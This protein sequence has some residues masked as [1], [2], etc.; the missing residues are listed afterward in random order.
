MT[1]P[2]YIIP[3]RICALPGCSVD[4]TDYHQNALYCTTA[5][6]K[7]NANN[8]HRPPVRTKPRPKG[9]KWLNSHGYVMIKIDDQNN[10]MMEHRYVMSQHLGRSLLSTESV[11][12]I[13]GDKTD[14]H[15]DNLELWSK[16]QPAGQR[17]SDKIEW[18]IAFL[19]AYGYQ[20][21]PDPSDTA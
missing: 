10:V 1:D 17:V 20:V 18:A 4:I 16:S 11:H 15:I 9:A 13:N 8:P 12:H 2:D 14:N 5:H 6:Q 19:E 21:T 7:L 3:E